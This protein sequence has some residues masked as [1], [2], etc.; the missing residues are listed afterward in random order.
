ML[1]IRFLSPLLA[2]AVAGS[3]FLPETSRNLLALA[4]EYEEQLPAL[5]QAHREISEDVHKLKNDA[6]KEMEQVTDKLSIT[7]K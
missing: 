4:T 5:S 3:Y 7:K 2:T 1:P 6:A